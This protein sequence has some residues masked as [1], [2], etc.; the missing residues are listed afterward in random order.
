MRL[1]TMIHGVLAF[2]FNTIILALAVN[3]LLDLLK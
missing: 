2:A 3:V 1:V